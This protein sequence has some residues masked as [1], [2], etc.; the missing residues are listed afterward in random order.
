MDSLTSR[1]K[2]ILTFIQSYIKKKSYPPSVR[3][4]GEALGLSSSSTV[5]AHLI[6]LEKKGFIKK[7]PTKPRT[8]KVLLDVS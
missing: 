5:H 2:E 4:I 1:Q 3:E 7:D 8:L 6:K